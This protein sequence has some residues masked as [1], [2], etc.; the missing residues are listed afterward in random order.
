MKK[1]KILLDLKIKYLNIFHYN[2][3]YF[4]FSIDYDNKMNISDY[5]PFANGL[6]YNSY[7]NNTTYINQ[8]NALSYFTT[9]TKTASGT[10]TSI[11]YSNSSFNTLDTYTQSSSIPIN[12]AL[13]F[14]GYF[15]PTITGVWTFTF[16]DDDVIS[17]WIS[18]QPQLISS[19]LPTLT[20]SN[21][22]NTKLGI[23]QANPTLA[24][25][26]SFTSNNFNIVSNDFRNGSYSCSASSS[27]SASYDAYTALRS[28][29]NYYSSWIS[30]L[31]QSYAYNT[32]GVYNG[33][34]LTQSS[35]SSLAGEWIQIKLP[36]SLI[37]TSYSLFPRQGGE[38]SCPK[39]WYIVGSNDGISWVLLDTKTNIAVSTFSS[40]QTYTVTGQ[41]IPYSYFRF[42]ANTTNGQTYVSLSQWNINGYSAISTYQTTLTVGNSYP[43]L[44]NYGQ[45][46]ANA[47]CQ[48]GITPP[49]GTITYDGT[50]YFFN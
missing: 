34:S 8:T 24:V 47:K 6:K 28:A 7:A 15:I 49:S 13:S 37:L 44:L 17:F 46:S 12:F 29:G 3:S 31:S 10:V 39:N 33:N 18:N 41:T 35:S 23:I 27:Y 42:I 48:M 9:A 14:Y 4:L 45:A 43:M 19:F 32:S 30:N 26:P 5:T 11:N 20:T 22:N 38:T 50:P 36:Y 1:I 40:L 2:M 21:I 25:Y 16:N